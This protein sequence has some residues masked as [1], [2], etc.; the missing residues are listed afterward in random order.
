MEVKEQRSVE[1][2]EEQRIVE[3]LTLLM[4]GRHSRMLNISLAFPAGSSGRQTLSPSTI[5]SKSALAK[6]GSGISRR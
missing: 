1:E 4:S 5:M 6:S 3:E 2:A